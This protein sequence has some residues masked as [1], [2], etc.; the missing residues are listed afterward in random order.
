MTHEQTQGGDLSTRNSSL[1]KPTWSPPPSLLQRR[2]VARAHLRHYHDIAPRGG[3]A[4][5]VPAQAAAE[6]D[7]HAAAAAAGS[8][9]VRSSRSQ[10]THAVA[11]W[12]CAT[13]CDSRREF[14]ISATE[15]THTCNPGHRT[16]ALPRALICRDQRP[17]SLLQSCTQ[18]LHRLPVSADTRGLCCSA[19]WA[20]CG[21]R[22]CR[23]P[24]STYATTPPS[25]WSSC[26]GRASRWVP[27]F[28]NTSWRR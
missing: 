10:R 7:P 8:Q 28:H 24:S 16:V 6:R 5:S 18:R 23:T 19:W 2:R 26:S 15:P 22:T 4:A 3:A 13:P 27:R 25:S 1:P 11:L 9:P 21:P 20:T 12:R 17:A 14:R